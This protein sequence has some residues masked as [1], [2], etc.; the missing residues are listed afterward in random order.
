MEVVTGP[1]SSPTG[2]LFGHKV[3]VVLMNM[4]SVQSLTK[5]A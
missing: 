3:S 4:S 2:Y 5:L 1:R